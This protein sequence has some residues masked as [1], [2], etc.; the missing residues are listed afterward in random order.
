MKDGGCGAHSIDFYSSFMLFGGVWLTQHQTNLH[1]KKV[2]PSQQKQK[3]IKTKTKNIIQKEEK[4]WEK[5]KKYKMV[6]FAPP[7]AGPNISSSQW[8]LFFSYL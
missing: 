1:T 3:K 8:H 2:T 4:D 5:A 7:K 6:E